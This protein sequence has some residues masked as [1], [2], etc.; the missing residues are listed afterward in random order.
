[1]LVRLLF[2]GTFM[3]SVSD[4]PKFVIYW[5]GMTFR[6]VIKALESVQ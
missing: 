2:T 1:M 3:I 5:V 6:G 4:C